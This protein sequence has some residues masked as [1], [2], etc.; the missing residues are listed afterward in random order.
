MLTEDDVIDAVR[1]FLV[2]EGWTITRRATVSQ[3]GTDLVAE[4]NGETLEIEAKGAGSSRVGS[5]RYGEE[6]NSGQWTALGWL[7]APDL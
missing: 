5:A 4:R 1:D 7:E 3:P 2:H 6:F